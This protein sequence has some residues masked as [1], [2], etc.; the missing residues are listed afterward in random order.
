M[1]FKSYVSHSVC[2]LSHIDCD[3][4]SQQDSNVF[5]SE[6]AEFGGAHF[7]TSTNGYSG[8]GYVSLVDS[9]SFIQWNDIF[10]ESSR[11][12][13]MRFRYMAISHHSN[14]GSEIELFVDGLWRRTFNLKSEEGIIESWI[15]S[16]I[17]QLPLSTGYHSVRLQSRGKYDAKIVSLVSSSFLFSIFQLILTLLHLRVFIIS[18]SMDYLDYFYQSKGLHHDR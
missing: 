6:T 11:E 13:K 17:A 4:K 10:I 14:I 5:Q 12:Y 3:T 7:G 2:I 16:D 1:V 9:N 8:P 18:Q 15:D